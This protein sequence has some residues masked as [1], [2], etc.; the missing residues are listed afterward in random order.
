MQV[1][2]RIVRLSRACAFAYMH[3]CGRM[4]DTMRL[5][6]LGGNKEAVRYPPLYIKL[7]KRPE[8]IVGAWSTYGYVS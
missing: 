8:P 7:S 1:A 5:V 6:R 3:K 4:H 2:T